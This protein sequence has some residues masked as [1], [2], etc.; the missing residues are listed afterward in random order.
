MKC[1][2]QTKNPGHKETTEIDL[3]E[4]D[5]KKKKDGKKENFLY[6]LNEN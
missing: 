1:K 4:N 2:D 6:E 5:N 3:I